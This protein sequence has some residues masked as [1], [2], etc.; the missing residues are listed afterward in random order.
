MRRTDDS[1]AAPAA[2]MQRAVDSS[3]SIVVISAPSYITAT[4]RDIDWVPGLLGLRS[5]AM[6]AAFGANKCNKPLRDFR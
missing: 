6:L 4:S 5:I 1:V 2:A 3:P